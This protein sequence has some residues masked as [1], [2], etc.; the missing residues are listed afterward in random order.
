MCGASS[1]VLSVFIY[2]CG[3]FESAVVLKNFCGV[4]RISHSR[5]EERERGGFIKTSGDVW[6]AT[7]VAD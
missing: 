6:V 2:F 4:I 5:W 1:G 7:D 3:N